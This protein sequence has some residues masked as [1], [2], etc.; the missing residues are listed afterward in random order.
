VAQFDFH[1]RKDRLLYSN[2]FRTGY[3]SAA[4]AQAKPG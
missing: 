1:S 3:L 4:R 2:S